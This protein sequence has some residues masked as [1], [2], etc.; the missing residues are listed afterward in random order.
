M[1]SRDAADLP[2]AL[3]AHHTTEIK[4]LKRFLEAPGDIAHQGLP[5]INSQQ[6]FDKEFERV[7]QL[8][9][10]VLC[11]VKAGSDLQ[12]AVAMFRA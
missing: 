7:Q 5:L 10:G 4:V 6:T 8:T 11:L 2:L 3:Q 9:A 1:R 12:T